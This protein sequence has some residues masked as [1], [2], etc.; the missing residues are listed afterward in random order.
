MATSHHAV[1]DQ[2]IA[3]LEDFPSQ[4][5]IA[6]E[7]GTY[8]ESVPSDI[9][10]EYWLRA[11]N[12]CRRLKMIKRRQETVGNA[13]RRRWWQRRARVSGYRAVWWSNELQ[14]SARDL[15]CQWQELLANACELSEAYCP[16][17][18]ASDGT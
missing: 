9:A 5:D 4:D 11:A 17:R 3:A 1:F 10:E 13:M 6:K 18:N 14:R 16:R 12:I 2:C 8:L 15:R 7:L